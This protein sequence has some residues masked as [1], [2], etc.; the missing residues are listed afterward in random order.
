MRVIYDV[1]WTKEKGYFIE[2]NP[3]LH[4]SSFDTPLQAKEFVERL[5]RKKKEYEKWCDKRGVKCQ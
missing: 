3:A 2:S 1:R 5:E 4:I